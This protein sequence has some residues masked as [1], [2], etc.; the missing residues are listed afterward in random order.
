MEYLVEHGADKDVQAHNKSTPVD[1]CNDDSLRQ[2]L[3]SATSDSKE[4]FF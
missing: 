4:F 2:L 1:V 3:Q